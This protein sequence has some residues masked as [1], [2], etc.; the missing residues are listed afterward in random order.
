MIICSAEIQYIVYHV[1]LV[2]V[3]DVT[4]VRYQ[5]SSIL[6]VCWINKEGCQILAMLEDAAGKQI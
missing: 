6:C 5:F 3:S 1:Q 2:V 4:F